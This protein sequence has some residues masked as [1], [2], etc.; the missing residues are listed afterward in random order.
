MG[1]RIDLASEANTSSSDALIWASA[2][3][4]GSAGPA[5]SGGFERIAVQMPLEREVR[6]PHARPSAD[7]TEILGLVRPYLLVPSE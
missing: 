5:C 6:L 3:Y 2:D 1:E 4:L 7:H